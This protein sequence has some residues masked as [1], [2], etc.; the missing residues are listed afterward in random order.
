[1]RA[2]SIERFGGPEVL[3]VR[4]LEP[5]SPGPGEAL[6]DVAVSGVNYIDVYHRTGR[7]PN[8]LPLVIGSEGAGTVATVGEGVT[9]VAVGDRVA[10]V[11]TLGS[12]AEQAV[13]QANRLVPVP[14]ELDIEVAA[15]ALLQGLTAHYLTRTTYPIKPGDVV[16][17]HAA[18]GGMGL[19]LTQLAAHLGAR[20]VATASTAEKQALALRAG[21]EI[22]VGYDEVGDA[23]RAAT[24]G[25]G[26][27]AVYDGVGK[28]TFAASLAALRPRGM[29]AVYGAASGPVPPLDIMQ[30]TAA[31][32]IVLTRPT[33]GHF[34]ATDEELQGRSTDLFGWILDGHLRFPAIQRYPLDRARQAH[35][36]LESRRTT[37]KLLL[38]P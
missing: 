16:L 19:L 6:V 5:L 17:V 10:W 28:D 38:V 29:F 1:L 9:D 8:E 34:V 25:T 14:A 18:A 7:Y 15:A 36:D 32:S 35:E 2:V 30:L 22:A 20:V 13:V 31:G 33:L 11:L 24:G 4:D 3:T 37:G 27:A 26:V 12:Y 23:V 21:A